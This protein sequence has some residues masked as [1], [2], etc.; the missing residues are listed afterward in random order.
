M[1]AMN[2]L[3]YSS[4][5]GDWGRRTPHPHTFGS[6]QLVNSRFRLPQGKPPLHFASNLQRFP[7]DK[8]RLSP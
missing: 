8:A 6:S 1:A 5:L 2:D 3:R 7:D 4:I